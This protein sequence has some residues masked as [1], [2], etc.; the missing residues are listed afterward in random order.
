M[1][2][3]YL[4]INAIDLYLSLFLKLNIS[5]I[6]FDVNNF[7]IIMKSFERESLDSQKSIYIKWK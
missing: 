4:L 1:I 5:L 6:I 3:F 7:A 2:N